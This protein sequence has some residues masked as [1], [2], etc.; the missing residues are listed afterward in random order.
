MLWACPA[1]CGMS[2]AGTKHLRSSRGWRTWLLQLCALIA[3]NLGQSQDMGAAGAAAEPCRGWQNQPRSAGS[4]GPECLSLRGG[5]FISPHLESGHGVCP[6][7]EVTAWL[8]RARPLKQHKANDPSL[9]STPR[10]CTSKELKLG[11]GFCQL[12]VPPC[13]SATREVPRAPHRATAEASSPDG[14]R[15]W[16]LPV[17][18]ALLLPASPSARRTLLYGETL[19]GSIPICLRQG[20]PAAAAGEVIAVPWTCPGLGTGGT[21]HRSPPVPFGCGDTPQPMPAWPPAPRAAA[22]SGTPRG[23]VGG[24][25]G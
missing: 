22:C 15:I 25:P 23:A 20:F 2:N 18:F 24:H 14:A 9:A 3:P 12:A 17:G 4:P 16:Q 19:A 13:S 6:L 21:C 1:V 5:M 11:L 10:F 8:C 7:P